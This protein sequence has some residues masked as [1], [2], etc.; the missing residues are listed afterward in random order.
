MEENTSNHIPQ[1]PGS[2]LNTPIV[3]GEPRKKGPW[4][5]E[6]MML[7]AQVSAWTL[8]PL[9]IGLIAGKWFKQQFKSDFWM[10][11]SIGAAFIISMIGVVRSTMS[12]FKQIMKDD[13]K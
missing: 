3:I 11:V 1:K 8:V 4:W 12:Q 10:Y 6:S 13:G 5:R 7:F 9:F 2:I